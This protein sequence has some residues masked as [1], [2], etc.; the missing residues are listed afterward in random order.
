MKI[1]FAVTV[2]NE[3]LELKRLLD[4]LFKYKRDEDEVVIQ[5]DSRKVTSDVISVIH[6]YLKKGIQYV[7]F[8]LNGDFAT[9]K[10]NLSSNCT[11]DWIFQID[12]DEYPHENL[13]KC[14][15]EL[16]DSAEYEEIEM[17]CVPRVNTVSGITE[18]WIKKWGWRIQ[19]INDIETI[20]YPDFQQRIFKRAPHIFWRN[21]VHEVISGHRY[22][23][24][25]PLDF[26]WSLFHPKTIDKQIKQNNFYATI[27]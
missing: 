11:G 25:L 6:G 16:I 4:H 20:N 10:N 27:K 26:E 2:C 9:F 3:N 23:A 7:E 18:E 21:K 8:P 15:P 22:Q 13:I 5:G 19:I 12:A 17:L 24:D 14:L 1:S